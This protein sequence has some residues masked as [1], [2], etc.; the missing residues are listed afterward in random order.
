MKREEFDSLP[1]R[2]QMDLLHRE[3]VYIGKQQSGNG[4]AILFQ[5]DDFYVEVFYKEYRSV[6]HHL[7]TTNS[8]D[9]LTPY[10][11]QIE[12]PVRNDG[13]TPQ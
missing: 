11:N 5:L 4:V 13:E 8:P 6:V 9:V 1:L 3:G 2:Q 10:L 12:N 7:H